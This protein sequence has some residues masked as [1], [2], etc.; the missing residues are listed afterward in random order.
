VSNIGIHFAVVCDTCVLLSKVGHIAD[1]LVQRPLSA[2]ECESV[3]ELRHLSKVTLPV[4]IRYPN[5]I[6]SKPDNVSAPIAGQVDWEPEMLLDR[7]AL[8]DTEVFHHKLGLT[9]GAIT[10]VVS[11]VDSC[12]SESNN[13]ATLIA[14]EVGDESRVFVHL[15]T[16][17]RTKVVDD[18][19]DRAER[20]TAVVQRCINSSI[21]TSNDIGPSIARQIG[22]ETWMLVD[23]PPPCTVAEVVNNSS[24]GG[25]SSIAIVAT[26]Q[27]VILSEADDIESSIA[28][29]V[30][31]EAKVSIKPP[32]SAIVSKV[33]DNEFGLAET[34]IAVVVGNEDS[35]VAKSNDIASADVPDVGHEADVL[36]GAPSSSR[37]GEIAED[38]FGRIG[39]SVIA[40]VGGDPDTVLAEPYDIGHPIASGV[41][42]ETDVSI[43]GP[44]SVVEAEVFDYGDGLELEGVAHDDNAILPETN[45]I[46]DAW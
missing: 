43:D 19:V 13:I 28:H 8:L 3:N 41:G 12:I 21:T 20:S 45:D 11:D 9:K 35:I 24:T 44:S 15:P 26:D 40:V 2:I 10:V 29:D 33:G 31:E 1:R 7:P 25:E 6:L 46:C 39:E 30:S 16:L 14:R 42:D 36:V 4:I 38:H 17:G 34:P 18:P 32:A 23:A 5:R 37:V 22:D 27:H